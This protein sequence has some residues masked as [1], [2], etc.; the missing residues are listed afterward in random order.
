ML[1]TVNPAA[2]SRRHMRTQR[3]RRIVVRVRRVND[4]AI[5]AKEATA[6]VQILESI[7]SREKM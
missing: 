1:H 2:L 7:Y 3:L 6:V 4:R 5:L